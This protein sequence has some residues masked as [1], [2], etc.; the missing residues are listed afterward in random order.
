MSPLLHYLCLA[1]GV[2]APSLVWA[3]HGQDFL[4]VESPAVPQPGSWY[5]TVDGQAAL[6]RDIEE[7]ASFAPA[8]RVG[9]TP[10]L[11]LELHA[12][13]EETAD[14]GWAF[15]S[16]APAV[17]L[18]LTDPG[19]PDGLKAGLSA[20]Y[21]FAS[22]ATAADKL[23]LRL[24]L[25]AGST[26][27]KWADNL[28]ASR[29]QGGDSDIGM[30]LGVRHVVRPRLAVGVEGEGSLRRAEGAKLLVAAYFESDRLGTI[31]LGLGAERVESGDHVPVAQAGWVLPLHSPR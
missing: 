29:E 10:R 17:H 16:I 12:H 4:L 3:H 7:R 24:S 28:L 5:L 11:A 27:T 15:E 18:L 9:L 23:E 14:E 30:A 22:Q 6:S 26:R 31:K 21:E 25:E 20:E 19:K 1:G 8:L 2:L 13:A